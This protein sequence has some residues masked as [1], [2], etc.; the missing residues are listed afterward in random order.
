[1]HSSIILLSLSICSTLFITT[2]CLPNAQS[3]PSRNHNAAPR[4]E[5]TSEVNSIEGPLTPYDQPPNTPNPLSI[6]TAN[7]TNPTFQGRRTH[8]E[9]H[10]LSFLIWSDAHT[11]LVKTMTASFR[12]AATSAANDFALGV[13]TGAQSGVLFF[14]YGA[15]VLMIYYV[16]KK[17]LID[18]I[19]E[20]FASVLEAMYPV[21][22][23]LVWCGLVTFICY[24][25]G[26]FDGKHRV[27]G[28]PEMEW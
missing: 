6:R 2:T 9:Y 5:A 20:A 11:H 22:Y 16:D 25:D 24:L 15:F 1:M 8:I 7:T 18:A 10:D 17:Y 19:L 13:K 26:N 27:Q 21:T 28:L 14:S 12:A 4:L 23:S 3:H